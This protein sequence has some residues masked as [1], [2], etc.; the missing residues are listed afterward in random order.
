MKVLLKTEAQTA[1]PLQFSVVTEV[2]RLVAR[3]VKAPR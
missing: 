2:V 1:L 3:K